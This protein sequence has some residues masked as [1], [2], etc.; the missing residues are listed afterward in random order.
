M[1]FKAMALEQRQTAF[2]G[3]CKA[4]I[5]WVECF[6]P[7]QEELSAYKRSQPTRNKTKAEMRIGD[8][9]ISQNRLT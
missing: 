9:N 2:R 8:Q 1:E 6:A 4:M 7:S 5:R 3:R